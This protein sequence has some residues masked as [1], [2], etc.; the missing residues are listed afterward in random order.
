MKSRKFRTLYL[1]IFSFALLCCSGPSAKRAEAPLPLE[2]ELQAVGEEDAGSDAFKLDYE[3]Y[4]LANGLTVILHRDTSDPIV[5]M[6]TVVHVGS[7]REKP[8]RTGFAHF[9]EH[10]SFNNSENV[11]MGANR[12]MIDELGGT[13]NGGTWEDATIYYEVVPTDAF[14]KLMWIDSDRFGYMINTVKE[15]TLEREKQVVKNEKRQRVD[16]RAYGHTDHVIRKALYPKGHPYSWTV[17]GDLED[18]QRATLTDVRQFYDEFYVPANA[19]LV[20]AGDIDIAKTK[21]LVGNWFGEIKAGD[22]VENLAAM[23]VTLAA[24]RRIAHLDAFAETAEL[25]RTYPTVPQYHEDS[26]ALE[27]LGAILA[28]GKTAPLFRSIVM[29]AKQSSSVSAYQDSGELAGTFSIAVRANPGVDLDDVYSSTEVALGRFEK[30]GF[31]DEDLQRFKARRE[32][33]FYSG[34][35]SVLDKALKLGIYQEFAGDPDYMLVERDRIRALSREDIMRV[36]EKY[37]QDKPAIITSFVPKN[38]PVSMMEKSGMARVV[39]EDIVAGAEKEFVE[40]DS[41]DFPRTPTKHDRSEPALGPLPVVKVPAIWRVQL[42][43]GLPIVGM[44]HRELP[45]VEFSLRIDG[46]QRVDP[47][48]LLGVASLTAELMNEGTKNKTPAE[49]EDA[50]ELLGA[51]LQVYATSTGVHITGRSLAKNMDAVFGLMTEMLLE[52]RFDAEEFARLKARRLARI[53]ERDGDPQAVASLAFYRQI[54]GD[55]H[56]AGQPFAG[57]QETVQKIE[58]TDIKKYYESNFGINHASLHVVGAITGPEVQKSL[59]RLDRGWIAQSAALPA[60]PEPATS[61]ASKLFFV[62]MPGAKQSV[63]F[64]GRSVA[65]GDDPDFYRLR[66]AGNRLGSGSSARLTQ[67]LRIEKGYTYGAY[68]SLQRTPYRGAFVASSQVRS[69]VTAA[70]LAIFKDLIGNYAATFADADLAI[71]KNLINK[72]DTRRFE[73]IGDLLTV[74][75]TMTQFGLPEDYVQREGAELASLSLTD[76]QAAIAKLIVMKE[77]T[78]VV[79]G[80]AKTQLRGLGKLGFGKPILLDRKGQRL[81]SR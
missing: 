44:E 16:N 74:L 8:G 25:R 41:N 50:I 21:E 55:D 48:E 67:R 32:T 54:Y 31:R 58:I 57:S 42:A 79:V 56:V 28:D 70:S 59:A 75:E 10:M 46:G 45:L 47:K 24:N 63:I 71:T 23:P 6:A 15:A 49:L 62:D 77:M 27:A 73:E 11:P 12:K 65:S 1:S 60:F 40:S 43:G 4:T 14:E 9:F 30:E 5:A 52:P 80:D 35:A 33:A 34:F 37:I 17:I 7:S 81:N 2:K 29:D 13:R 18:L 36:Y 68:S 38:Q 39:E 51:S 3:R 53:R 22:G 61:A 76:L 20:I 66:V 78:V 19:T 64:M 69:N 26:Y 72:A